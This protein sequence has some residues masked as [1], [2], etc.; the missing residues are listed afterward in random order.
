MAKLNSKF[1]LLD[2]DIKEPR[3]STKKYCMPRGAAAA[4][5]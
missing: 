4:F 5:F 3:V 1:E 2:E